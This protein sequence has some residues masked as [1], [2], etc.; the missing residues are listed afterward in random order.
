MNQQAIGVY[1]AVLK[2]VLEDAHIYMEINDDAIII[3]S[4]GYAVPPIKLGQIANFNAPSL[5]R[6]PKIMF[7]FDALDLAE[8]RGLKNG[9][10]GTCFTNNWSQ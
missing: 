10:T 4:P 1:A 5:I 3:K 7:V 6:N 9:G 8:Q 2:G